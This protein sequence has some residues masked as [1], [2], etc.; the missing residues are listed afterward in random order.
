MPAQD[1]EEFG[2]IL[3]RA[4][5]DALWIELHE[6]GAMCA[7][8]SSVSS[9]DISPDVAWVAG[10]V[11]HTPLRSAMISLL[12]STK[13]I[14]WVHSSGSGLDLHPFPMLR[15]R[16]VVVTGARVN[17]PAIAEFV[18]RAVLAR[19]QR[20]DLWEQAQVR[21]EWRRH[22]VREA[23]GTTWLLLGVGA[24]GTRV[25]AAARALG[26]RT[27][28]VRRSAERC[29]AVDQVLPRSQIADFLP[30]ADVVVLALPHRDDLPPLVDSDF[31]ARMSTG[32][33]LVN[34][35]RGSL[36]DQAALLRALDR[37]I[38]DFAVLDVFAV[39]PLPSSSPLWRHPRVAISPHN[40]QA[41]LA[42]YERGAR[43]FAQH[44][45]EYSVS[46][47]VATSLPEEC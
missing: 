43:V 36:V 21:A 25:A 41:S 7:D 39:E 12:E 3:R 42:R 5:P 44:L 27:V 13:T 6:D 20:S 45:A 46:G 18:I 47:R 30:K 9:E 29:A 34:V 2:G 22:D 19:L 24:I 17:S 37:G 23:N 32:S 40:S 4:V 28:G 14:R 1:L 16:G 38:P 11:F 35:A 33:I 26:A 15:H 8:G 10:R 31:L